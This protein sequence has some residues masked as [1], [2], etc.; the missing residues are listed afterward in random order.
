MSRVYFCVMRGCLPGKS[1]L[2]LQSCDF[3]P[4]GLLMMPKIELICDTLL[5]LFVP[6]WSVGSVLFLVSWAVLMGPVAYIKHLASGSRLPFTIAYFTS[7]G[8]TIYFA[9]GV[10]YLSR[11]YPSFTH[12]GQRLLASWKSVA[13]GM[14]LF[15]IYYPPHQPFYAA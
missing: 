12:S 5:T 1:C 8:L 6:R 14:L 2:L 11:C 13:A 9:T 3:G 15:C 7:I 4:C 10:S